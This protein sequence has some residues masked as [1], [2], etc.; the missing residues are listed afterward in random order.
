MKKIYNYNGLY[1]IYES[2]IS[3]LINIIHESDFQRLITD[4]H[5]QKIYDYQVKYFKEY[6]KFN[7]I[8][9]ILIGCV[10]KKYYVIDGQHRLACCKLLMDKYKDFTVIVNIYERETEEELYEL[11]HIFNRSKPVTLYC[12]LTQHIII[13]NLEKH[14]KTK[15]S[16]Y[17]KKTDNPIVPNFNL[18]H[19]IDGLL[20]SDILFM[21]NIT[22]SSEIIKLID[23]LNNYYKNI[24][25]KKK[26]NI[27]SKYYEKIKQLDDDE[28]LY[29]TFFKK[30]EWTGT[31]YMYKMNNIN[32]D[33]Q[34]HML[35]ID[36]YQV[37]KK[38]KNEVW[39]EE[40][41]DIIKG[42][43]YCCEEI[44]TFN[45]FETGHIISPIFGGVDNIENLK[46][47]CKSCNKNKGIQNVLNYKKLFE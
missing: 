15:Y 23:E 3:S 13:K 47:L 34:E 43:C 45:D 27:F 36:S 37:S 40:F 9:P 46:I 31:I 22:K 42:E 11:Y 28:L 19:F 10:K 16:K 5:V 6:N 41:G 2:D 4:T 24:S 26:I 7:F 33:E 38:I 30:Y 32:F 14:L 1:T 44:I 25:E 21:L 20:K 35:S 29:L 18:S 17:I 8:N 12:S 39:K